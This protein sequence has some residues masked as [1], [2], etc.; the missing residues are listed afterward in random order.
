MERYFHK[1]AL[2]GLQLAYAEGK[3]QEIMRKGFAI[4]EDDIVRE[5]VEHCLEVHNV[6]YSCNYNVKPYLVK[7]DVDAN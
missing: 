3:M 4:I 1:L 2:S 6:P 5:I 7:V